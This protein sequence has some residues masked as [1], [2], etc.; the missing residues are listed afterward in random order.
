ML[1]AFAVPLM[2]VFCFAGV[3]AS[4][5]R[6][7]VR[8]KFR[9]PP[10]RRWLTAVVAS[11]SLAF[12]IPATGSDAG[13]QTAASTP[14]SVDPAFNP[15]A[16]LGQTSSLT[17]LVR[18]PDG[19]ILVA[20]VFSSIDGAL[21]PG[22]VRLNPNGRLDAG[23]QPPPTLGTVEKIV[24]QPDG[25]ILISRSVNLDS[26]STRSELV[27]LNAD[28]SVDPGFGFDPGTTTGPF[29]PISAVILQPDGKILYGTSGGGGV[30]RLLSDGRRDFSFVALTGFESGIAALAVQ[31]DGKVLAGGSFTTV[32]GVESQRL[33]RLRADG[34]LDTAF[35]GASGNEGL[36]FPSDVRSITV[37][38]NGKILV[39][40]AFTPIG[41]STL[42]QGLTRLN[43]NGT[44]DT[45]FRPA[46]ELAAAANR[47]VLQGDGNLLVNVPTDA[48]FVFPPPLGAASATQIGVGS[49]A[50]TTTAA[51]LNRSV[52][53]TSRLYRLQ[54]DGRPDPGFLP[55]T[56]YG[57]P[58]GEDV[59]TGLA[60]TTGGKILL[61]GRFN[62]VN[63]SARA[64]LAQLDASGELTAGFDPAPQLPGSVNALLPL[65]D[66][67]FVVSG[68]FAT[69]DGSLHA[70]LARFRAD[71]SVDGAF[72]AET[73]GTVLAMARFPDD[74]AI[75]LAGE[76]RH[77]NG[78]IRSR[79]ARI[80]ANG[81]LDSAFAL[82][83]GLDFFPAAAAVQADGKIL[84]GGSRTVLAESLPPPLIRLNRDGSLD[85]GFQPVFGGNSAIERI[86]VQPDGGILISGGLQSPG[87]NTLVYQL[88]RLLP[89]GSR[90]AGFGV[91]TGLGEFPVGS[92]V[93][94]PDGRIL[95]NRGVYP[96]ARP[97]ESSIL[98]LLPDGRRDPG[99]QAPP[100]A[101]GA[102]AAV[103]A[104]GKIL[105]VNRDMDVSGSV[106]P[107][108]LRLNGDGSL[109]A[110]FHATVFDAPYFSGASVAAVAALA[111]GGVLVGGFFSTVDDQIHHGLARLEGGPAV[112]GFF[113]GQM[114]VGDN[115]Y[116]LD[117]FG[118]Y[119]RGF[120]PYVYH[121]ELGW[122]Y[123]FDSRDAARGA[124]FY[125][126][127]LRGF[128]YTS[129]TLF[130]YLY[131]F[132]AGAFLYYFRGTTHPRVFAN[133]K[134]GQFVFSE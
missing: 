98:R 16:G 101:G 38:P 90:D 43:A 10:P 71:G 37:Q 48:N 23:F 86:V 69:A 81:A 66:G 21:R 31:G 82:T 54:P 85:A 97:G 70:N 114:S 57:P 55:A 40:G 120:F 32:D 77:V 127:G 8:K 52:V 45:N 78:V 91:E 125:D 124:F 111:D 87:A 107:Q 123:F 33:V 92:F 100:G 134:T 58:A 67:Q 47:V 94:Q 24:L 68:S 60:L 53:V 133:L 74:G 80:G 25:K 72:V 35:P 128:L 130:P 115:W 110:G 11:V 113:A 104:D 27:R 102:A 73:D 39:V 7:A 64:S 129:P 1:S 65:P 15:G 88:V 99:F 83:N 121:T 13:A 18:Q 63:E 96:A 44:L 106:L 4:V 34:R 119:Y 51:D 93:L 56:I 6:M 116:H 131:D 12:L 112:P 5:S 42:R 3:R 122:L 29:H 118:D 22:F 75:L 9:R 41:S 46:P 14:G 26:G 17:A 19:K 49:A 30:V 28:G 50:A 132:N 89:D 108:V 103:Q 95:L 109:D 79:L 62:A 36:L 117:F 105:V 59:I 20:G 84:V 2:R 126:F 61:G 76:F